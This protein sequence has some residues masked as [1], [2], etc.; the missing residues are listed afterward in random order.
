MIRIATFVA[1]VL[2]LSSTCIS[3]TRYKGWSLLTTEARDTIIQGPYNDFVMMTAKRMV[4]DQLGGE[5]LV[6]IVQ[7]NKIIRSLEIEVDAVSNSLMLSN[8]QRDQA[9]DEVSRMRD[10]LMKCGK[11]NAAKG[12]WA[13]IG[14]TAL[15]VIAAAI[16]A[17]ILVF[18]VAP[19]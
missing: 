1:F 15:I 14:K 12:V 4:S 8:S 17:G 16:I 19:A 10:D 13:T 5:R 7:L 11:E 18:F 3:Q 9:I 2:T 6:A